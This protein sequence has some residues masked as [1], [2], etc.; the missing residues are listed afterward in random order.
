MKGDP[1]VLFH[2]TDVALAAGFIPAATL[3]PIPPASLGGRVCMKGN[4]LVPFHNKR[5]P[6]LHIAPARYE[7][8]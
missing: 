8:L 3:F 7:R 5:A 6:E 4:P 2:K 1:W